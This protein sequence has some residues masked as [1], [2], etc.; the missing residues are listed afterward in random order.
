MKNTNG[1]IIS[2]LSRDISNNKYIYLMLIPVLIYYIIFHY[3]PMYGV[4]IA[5]KDFSPAKGILGSKWIGFYNFEL[6][7]NSRYFIRI[8]RNTILIS[9]YSLIFG[10]PAPIL[11]ALLLNEIKHKTFKRVVQTS[12]YLPHFISLVVVCGM[13]VDFT[14]SSGFITQI[15]T[16]FGGSG[17]NMLM[18]KELFRTIYVSSGVWQSFGWNSIIYLATLSTIDPCLYEAA[19]LDG[20]G[21]LRQAI[22]ITLPGI[23]PTIVILLILN[24]GRMLGVGFEKIILLYNT[25]TYETADVISSFVYRKGLLEFDFSYSAAVGLFNS[26]ANF[27]FLVGANFI[28]RKASETSLW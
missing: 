4:I 10:F 6:F 20:A 25:S 26:M 13:I 15:A 7:F 2:K 18:Q 5:F 24:M 28:S 11:M 12:T 27:I 3:A 17:R 1:T 22:H 9:L 14:S 8:L 21:R 19:V 23:M 16:L